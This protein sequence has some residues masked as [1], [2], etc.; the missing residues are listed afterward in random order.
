[1]SP[2]REPHPIALHYQMWFRQ[3]SF[4]QMVLAG[5]VLPQDHYT[6]K[7]HFSLILYRKAIDFTCHGR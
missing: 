7:C 6:I 2:I 3:P 4:W 1:M 5:G